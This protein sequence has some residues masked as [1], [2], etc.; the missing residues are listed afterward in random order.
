M[1]RTC[2]HCFYLF[3][4]KILFMFREGERDRNINV[5]LPLTHSLLGTQPTTQACAPD[6]EYNQ[7]PFGLQAGTK[8][9]ESHQLGLFSLLLEREKEGENKRERTM[10]AR[11]TVFHT[12]WRGD[13]TRPDQRAN[14]Q[15]RYVPFQK[16]NPQL[17][18]YRMTPQPLSHTGQVHHDFF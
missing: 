17:F 12:D 15:P 7:R 13:L 10:D 14:A 11:E 5:W 9:T 18:S 3:I 4:F 1:L 16:S 8:S 2:L 6:R